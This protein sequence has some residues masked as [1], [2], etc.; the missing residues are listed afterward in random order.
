M[1]ESKRVDPFFISKIVVT[2]FQEQSKKGCMYMT[3]NFEKFKHFEGTDKELEDI[4]SKEARISDETKS[5]K[6]ITVYGFDT[7][8][9]RKTYLSNLIESIGAELSGNLDDYWGEKEKECYS[10]FLD[11]R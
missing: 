1:S 3:L 2:F 10:F 4:C 7:Y 11:H 9:N 5:L 6:V 8:E